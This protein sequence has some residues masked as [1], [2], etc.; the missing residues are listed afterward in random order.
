MSAAQYVKPGAMFVIR[1]SFGPDVFALIIA[2]APRGAI[3]YSVAMDGNSA[4][5]T[6]VSDSADDFAA[7]GWKFV[8]MK[9]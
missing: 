5:V 6:R 7:D 4:A 8:G 9:T 3:A 1:D 2:Q